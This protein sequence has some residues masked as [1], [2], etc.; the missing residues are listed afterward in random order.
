MRTSKSFQ[1][2]GPR[3][4]MRLGKYRHSSSLADLTADDQ[5]ERGQLSHW[6]RSKQHKSTDDLDRSPLQQVTEE[7]EIEK[8][9][10][11][12]AHSL[13]GPPPPPPL[14]KAKKK[15]KSK[16]FS[17]QLWRKNSHPVLVDAPFPT[18]SENLPTPTESQPLSATP[19]PT[20]IQPAASL[21]QDK[22]FIPPP[23][24]PP[25]SGPSNW[26]SYGYV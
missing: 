17:L 14:N 26:N 7:A 15:S 16:K 18:I 21:P 4:K 24:S 9:L 23:P 25:H 11:S 8:N 19:K 13:H 12:R 3:K 2:S 10:R 22:P 20:V 5:F 1:V 6:E